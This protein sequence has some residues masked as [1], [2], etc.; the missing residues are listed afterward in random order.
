MGVGSVAHSISEGGS[1]FVSVEEEEVEV[2]VV[3]GLPPVLPLV[4]SQRSGFAQIDRWNV[5]EVFARRAS[6]MRTVP[7]FL[8]FFE[9]G[10]LLKNAFLVGGLLLQPLLLLLPLSL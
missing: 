5:Q 2:S 3:A 4:A 10:S 8:N 7:R 9:Q 6:V 1:A